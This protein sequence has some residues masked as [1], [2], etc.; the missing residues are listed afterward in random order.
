MLFLTLSNIDM[1]FLEQELT[2]KFYII[3]EALPIT[4]QVKFISKIDFAK[5]ALNAKSEMFVIYVTVLQ[6]SLS[7]ITIHPFEAA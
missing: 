5:A 2:W 1:W 7:D 6:A 4:K 3:D